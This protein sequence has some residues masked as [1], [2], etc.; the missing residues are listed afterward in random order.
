VQDA[1]DVSCVL[2][3]LALEGKPDQKKEQ[4]G[5]VLVNADG[6][7]R[8]MR[9]VGTWQG[10]DEMIDSVNAVLRDREMSII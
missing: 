5:I 7:G 6:E 1:F 3:V 4:S 8:D 2:V 10:V 9:K